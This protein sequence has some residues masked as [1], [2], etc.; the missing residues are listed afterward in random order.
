MKPVEFKIMKGF[1]EVYLKPRGWTQQQLCIATG[2][3]PSQVS[4]YLSGKQE[5][6]IQFLR[7]VCYI[8][9]IDLKDIIVT[10]FNK[11]FQGE[12]NAENHQESER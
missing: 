12:P 2:Y 9:R 3:D 5:P 10:Q 1:I 6:S 11:I 4:R 7:K 8:L